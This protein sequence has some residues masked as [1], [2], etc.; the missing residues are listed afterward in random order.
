VDSI[1]IFG[2][3]SSELVKSFTSILTDSLGVLQDSGTAYIY[4]DT[5]SKKIFIAPTP[6]SAPN[7]SNYTLI[8]SYNSSY[9]INNVKLNPVFVDTGSDV[10]IDF[11]YDNSKVLSGTIE[12]HKDGIT[13][14]Q[15]FTK[16]I[17][18]SGGYSLNTQED[19]YPGGP[20]SN[21][22]NF[23]ANG[24]LISWSVTTLPYTNPRFSDSLVYDDTGNVASVIENDSFHT[25]QLNAF[26][27]T[28]RGVKG[29]EYSTLNK[30]LY[31]GI[32]QLPSANVSNAGRTASELNGFANHLFYQFTNY[33][34]SSVKVYQQVTNSYVTFNTNVQL[35]SKNRLLSFKMY[36]SDGT[37][38]YEKIKLDYYK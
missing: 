16:T 12:T 36:Y 18:P 29:N 9:Q 37:F 26:E 30:I 23:D 31:N 2:L 1:K 22:Y 14:A 15:N 21:T 13:K 6:I 33:P 24:K 5:L 25:S 38:Y 4:Y 32:S 27:M 28:S 7:P 17:L 3:D 8:Y 11:L 34:A 35:D 20:S 19:S 10:S